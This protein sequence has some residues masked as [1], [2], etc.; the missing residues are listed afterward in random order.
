MKPNKTNKTHGFALLILCFAARNNGE[1]GLNTLL[2][3][4]A[5]R[6]SRERN[7]WMKMVWP[8]L[9]IQKDV[10]VRP[11]LRRAVGMLRQKRKG[12]TPFIEVVKQGRLK[13]IRLVLSHNL[14]RFCCS[15]PNFGAEFVCSRW[16]VSKMADDSSWASGLICP[17]T[18]PLINEVVGK[19]YFHRPVGI[20]PSDPHFA[21][22]YQIFL[23][24]QEIRLKPQRE[25]VVE[26]IQKVKQE[27]MKFAAKIDPYAMKI[28]N[29]L[30]GFD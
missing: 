7:Q 1:I 14:V 10:D 5:D 12:G 19:V 27:G 9:C 21:N 11:L 25:S 30:W 22:L 16:F 13:V 24:R 3:Q 28:R 4:L 18:I 26:L 29:Q 23:L 15:D 17:L 2:S 20:T 8:W 6:K